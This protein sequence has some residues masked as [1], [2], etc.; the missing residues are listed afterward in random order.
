MSDTKN[1]SRRAILSA[2]PAAAIG[3]TAIPILALASV[4]P[5]FAL[6]ERHRKTHEVFG[7]ACHLTDEVAAELEGR[8]VT[9]ADQ[10]FYNLAGEA[11]E[12]A[13]EAL[14]DCVP[15]TTAGVS[16]ELEYLRLLLRE[17]EHV[18]LALA[19]IAKSPAL[20]N[21]GGGLFAFL[22]NGVVDSAHLCT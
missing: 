1:P 12:D 8:V 6:I 21:V 2:A 10:D 20:A 15:Q 7:D 5:V 4:D 13:F 3:L 16:A 19:N 18:E 17:Y 9:D 14:L 11:D 22:K